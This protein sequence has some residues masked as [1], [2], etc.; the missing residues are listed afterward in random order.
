MPEIT[1]HSCSAA[2][3]EVSNIGTNMLILVD[4]MLVDDYT[5][6]IRINKTFFISYIFISN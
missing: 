2:Q 1:D 3:A 4:K 6:R 5:K